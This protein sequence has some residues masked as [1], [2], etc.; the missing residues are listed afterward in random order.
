MG[1]KRESEQK[2]DSKKIILR[3]DG[4][5]AEDIISCPRTLTEF[6]RTKSAQWKY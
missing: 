3:A 2:V 5:R 6:V 1:D 4:S